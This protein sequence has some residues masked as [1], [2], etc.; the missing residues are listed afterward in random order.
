MQAAQH[1]WSNAVAFHS[2]QTD[3]EDEYCV[4]GIISQS[5]DI[6]N[7]CR[8]SLN[9]PQR[10][11]IFSPC[12]VNHPH[13]ARQIKIIIIT[14]KSDRMFDLPFGIFDVFSGLQYVITIGIFI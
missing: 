13:S 7:V 14:A 4:W 10:M 1:N 6:I 9:R 11:T 12:M 8:I 2:S 5:M 3:A